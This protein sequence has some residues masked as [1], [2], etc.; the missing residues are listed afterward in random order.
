MTRGVGLGI[1]VA[2]AAAFAASAAA[3][4]AYR[5]QVRKWRED[6]EARLKADGG[7][8][9][10]A[11]LFWLKDG[12]NRFGTDPSSEILLPVGSAPA[13]AGGPARSATASARHRAPPR[14]V[15]A[16]GPITTRPG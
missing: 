7:W 9:T 16:L 4:E 5:A 2:L 12:T 1:V 14:A 10:L 3:D 13:R 6:R 8:L 11:G 15:L